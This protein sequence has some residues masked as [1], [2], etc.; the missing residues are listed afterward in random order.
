MTTVIEPM[1][2][3]K[4]WRSRDV[5]YW[6]GTWGVV[7]SVVPRFAVA[8]FRTAPDAPAN[9]YMKSIIR[10]PRNRIEQ[11]IP[12]GVVSNSYTL[13]QHHDVAEKCFEGIRQSKVQ[14]TTLR[15][16]V[17]LTELGEWMNLRIYFPSEYDFV[18][19]ESDRL[20][21]R[22]ECYN[23]VDGSSRLI[24]LLG[25]LR[26]VCTNGLVIGETKTELRDIHDDQLDLDC[27]P[28]I[29]AG[30]MAKVSQ[31]LNRMRS[32]ERV[33]VKEDD[34]VPWVNKDVTEAWGKKAASRVFSICRTGYDAEFDDPF[35]Q[36]EAVEK[37][38]R[39]T[40]RVP[41]SPEMARNLFDVTQAMSWVATGRNSPDERLDW[42]SAVPRLVGRLANA[43]K[44]S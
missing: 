35:A 3:E 32:W 23:S 10:L 1:A 27:I 7:S 26:F 40:T 34:L 42:Q 37:P 44:G 22:L 17:G 11:P 20:G 16:E 39:L 24:I 33:G 18:R 15:C 41:G 6:A 38:M 29:I 28:D 31:D 8:D 9:P 30:G 19:N 5:K 4:R 25:W 21:L 14:T 13:A 2:E 43:L 12:V 36:G